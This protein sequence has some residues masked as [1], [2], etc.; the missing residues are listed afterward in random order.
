MGLKDFIKGSVLG[1]FVATICCIAPIVLILLGFGTAISMTVMHNFHLASIVSG[2][3]LMLLIV[4]YVI[5]RKSG[6]CNATTIKQNWK[7]I[8]ITIIFMVGVWAFFNYLIVAPV[9]SL[10]YNN[11]EVNQKPL[12]NLVEMAESHGMPELADIK[13]IPENEGIKIL[14]LKIEG[15][16]CGSCGPALGYDVKSILGVIEVNQ[17]GDEMVVIYG[18]VYESNGKVVLQLDTI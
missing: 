13:V 5:K 11:L 2:I 14:N 15:V 1:G 8:T 10:V 7:G 3:L 18:D 9:A 17:E 6:A 4:F 16:F 12:G